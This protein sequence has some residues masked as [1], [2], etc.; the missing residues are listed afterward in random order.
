MD[1][2]IGGIN[3]DKSKIATSTY[4]KIA[5]IY[6]KQYFN[7]LTD[8]P[9]ID[10]FLNKLRKGSSILDVGSGPG[11]FTKYML[12]RNFEVV[13]IDYS[14]EMLVTAE[15]MV[16]NGSFRF[17]DMRSLHFEG[18]SF[19]GLLVA[20]SLIHIPSEDIPKTLREFYRVLKS[21]GYI[22]I[23]AQKGQA[24]KI[25]DEPFMP[26]EK[27]FFNFFTKDRLKDFLKKSGF[28]IEYQEETDSQD[29]DSASDKVIYTIA[30][31]SE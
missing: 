1:S 9:Y 5:D 8:T 22:E 16:P 31:K 21:D 2:I 7:D 18:S 11:Q 27:M 10:K 26:S 4:E 17:M 25:I 13:G 14:K 19:D 24:D 23:I 28:V 30:K 3:M 6:T 15:K 29:P 20:Y 12:D